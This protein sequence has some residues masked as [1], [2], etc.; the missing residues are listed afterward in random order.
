MS[1]ESKKVRLPIETKC[2]VDKTDTM[3]VKHREDKGAVI[4]F[5]NGDPKTAYV[6]CSKNNGCGKEHLITTYWGN[7]E[8]ILDLTNEAAIN[9]LKNYEQRVQ[10]AIQN[11]PK[12]DESDTDSLKNL[13]IEPEQPLALL[14]Q[15]SQKQSEI[16]IELTLDQHL[17]AIQRHNT[18][19]A[20]K[21]QDLVDDTE[22]RNKNSK[23]EKLTSI[24]KHL[25]R[26]YF[27]EQKK[28]MCPVCNIRVISQ[29][30]FDGGHIF[31]ESK[32]GITDIINLM[33]IC[34]PCNNQMQAKHLYA[35]AWK[36]HRRALWSKKEVERFGIQSYY[37][38]NAVLE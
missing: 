21:F 26:I 24:K 15:E 6:Y 1:A 27:G 38:T 20:N 16:K 8:A 30:C 37:K 34:N 32:G 28:V 9:Y 33:P 11:E 2:P 23:K 7:D 29:D 35:Y 25:W 10:E 22:Q 4:C 18:F 36:V 5:R 14:N 12:A 3:Y 13:V 31:P 19:I 17:E